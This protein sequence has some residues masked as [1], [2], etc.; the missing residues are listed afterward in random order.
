[1]TFRA[2][3]TEGFED[4]ELRA[5]NAAMEVVMKHRALDEQTAH[6]LVHKASVGADYLSTVDPDI[7]AT[8]PAMDFGIAEDLELILAP[9]EPRLFGFAYVLVH[10]VVFGKRMVW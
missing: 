10:E 3:N 4:W 1:M 6:D 9:C 5:M 7:A 2:D 8:A